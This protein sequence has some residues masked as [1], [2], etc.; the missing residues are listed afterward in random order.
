MKKPT[1]KLVATTAV[2]AAAVATETAVNQPAAQA[3][4]AK[5]A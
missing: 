4:V 2:V 3:A 1:K 5:P